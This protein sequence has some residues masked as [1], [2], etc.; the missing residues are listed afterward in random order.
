MI[1]SVV[2][3]N[4]RY[5][6]N[7]GKP[8]LCRWW[9]PN[10]TPKPEQHQRAFLHPG[11]A[12]IKAAE[13]DRRISGG[14]FTQARAYTFGEAALHYIELK[15]FKQVYKISLRSY[16]KNGLRKYAAL[17]LAEVAQMRAELHQFCEA[18][19]RGEQYRSLFKGTCDMAVAEGVLPSHRLSDIILAKKTPGKRPFIRMD[20]DQL[21]VILAE[22]PERERALVL[23]MRGCGLRPGEAYGL[24]YDDFHDGIVEINRT[25]SGNVLDVPK[26]RDITFEPRKVPVPYWL[27]PVIEDHYA[28]F[29]HNGIMFPL[30]SNPEKYLNVGEFRIRWSKATAAAGLPNGNKDNSKNFVAYQLR[31]NWATDLRV[32]LEDLGLSMDDLDEWLGH[33]KLSRDVYAYIDQERIDRARGIHDPRVSN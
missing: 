25:W 10:G 2:I 5:P 14:E 19:A 28:R 18:E 11:D 13:M 31:K 26:L 15:P 9:V 22:L 16:V 20:K 12:A 6:R 33:S 1:R 23:V 27:G 29:G 21:N 30:R 17:P 7:S 24:H 32:H 3:P 4:P 8:W